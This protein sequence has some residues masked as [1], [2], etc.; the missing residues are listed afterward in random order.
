MRC[1]PLYAVLILIAG[2]LL[3]GCAADD[4][5]P[6]VTAEDRDGVE[7]IAHPDVEEWQDINQAPVQFE[8]KQTFG[9]ETEPEEAILPEPTSLA[10]DDRGNVY[11]YDGGDD[12]LVSFDADG[13]VRWSAGSP[14]QGPGEFQNVLGDPVW[15]GNDRLYISNQFGARLDVWSTDGAFETSFSLEGADASRLQTLG[16]YE[17]TVVLL[18]LRYGEGDALVVRFDPEQG[19][20]VDEFTL[21]VTPEPAPFFPGPATDATLDG[22]RLLVS[23]LKS[24]YHLFEFAMDGTPVREIVVEDDDHLAGAGTYRGEEGI[25]SMTVS[26]LWAPF[27]IADDVR[28]VFSHWLAGVTDADEFA[29]ARVQGTIDGGDIQQAA[30][31]DVLNDEGVITGR[32]EWSDLGESEMGVPVA[33]GPDGHLYTVVRAPYPHVRKYEVTVFR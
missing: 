12:R 14:G 31:L 19:A 26:D 16:M 30:A 10:T 18:A 24:A 28:L 1:A 32:F 25:R 21:D 9:V 4:T 22:E 7:Y 2:I 33:S 29:R 5:A 6:A 3:G 15:D 17:G 23:H 27:R 20:A 8:L 13:A 11:L